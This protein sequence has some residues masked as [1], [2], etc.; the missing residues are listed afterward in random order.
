MQSKKYKNINKTSNNN[1][2]VRNSKLS[3]VYFLFL[4]QFIF[5]TL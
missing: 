3:R 5:F 4:P 2:Q 1:K